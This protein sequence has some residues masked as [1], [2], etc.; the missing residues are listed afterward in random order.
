MHMA[1]QLKSLE[2]VRMLDQNGADARVRNFEDKSAID[3]AIESNEFR[4]IKL[5]FQA[6]NKYKRENFGTFVPSEAN[7]Q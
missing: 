7:I 2:M 1:V 6:N 5:H 4:E 3:I